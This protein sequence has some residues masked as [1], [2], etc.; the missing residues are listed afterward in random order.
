MLGHAL[1]LVPPALLALTLASCGA[2]AEPQAPPVAVIP[3]A[4]S[5]TAHAY[6][7]MAPPPRRDPLVGPRGETASLMGAH[8]KIVS[9]SGGEELLAATD[10]HPPS[11]DPALI[12]IEPTALLF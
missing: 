5:S 7:S 1:D 6:V 8:V 11:G 2:P 12:A 4:P 10:L 9:S 3:P